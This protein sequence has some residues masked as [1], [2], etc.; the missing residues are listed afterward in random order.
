MKAGDSSAEGTIL[1]VG[2]TRL[3]LAF[4]GAIMA[5]TGCTTFTM[6]PV[7]TAPGPPVKLTSNTPCP[8]VDFN[9]YFPT[10]LFGP[11]P[12]PGGYEFSFAW[13][14]RR[15]S[16]TGAIRTYASVVL[17][18]MNPDPAMTPGTYWIQPA[19]QTSGSRV[20]QTYQQQ[21]LRVLPA[22]T[23]SAVLTSRRGARIVMTGDGCRPGDAAIAGILPINQPALAFGDPKLIKYFGRHTVDAN[24]RWSVAANIASA[25]PTG[26]YYVRAECQTPA[27]DVRTGYAPRRLVLY[28]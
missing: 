7:T 11:P 1:K 5:L 22:R 14:P 4:V 10:L 3:A 9:D 16:W 26:S 18:P 24:G 21:Y 2:L 15:T 28:P 13:G 12:Q 23:F 27:G 6:W 8:A 20:L 25:A 17:D 19:C